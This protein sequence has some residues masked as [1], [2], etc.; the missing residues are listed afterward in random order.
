MLLALRTV[1][2]RSSKRAVNRGRLAPYD[3][4]LTRNECMAEFY[5]YKADII[6][7]LDI[8]GQ[9]D[10]IEPPQ[11]WTCFVRIRKVT[12]FNHNYE[13]LVVLL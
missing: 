11:A 2:S 1:S 9:P 5:F 12:D 3:Q 13:S 10:P 4:P 7:F 6:T 8:L